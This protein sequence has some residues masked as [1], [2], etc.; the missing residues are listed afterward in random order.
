MK[1]QRFGWDLP[2]GL[3][4]RCL[5]ILIVEPRFMALDETNERDD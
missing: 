2:S 3:C 4:V 1:E 5:L